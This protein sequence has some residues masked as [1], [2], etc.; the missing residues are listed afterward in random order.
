[1][2]FKRFLKKCEEFSICSEIGDK[3]GDI[4]LE[5]AEDRMTLYQIVIKGSGRMSSVFSSDY[6]EGDSNHNPFINLKRFL[7][8]H[9]IF[10]SYEPFHMYGFNTL[11]VN[12][13]WNGKLINQSFQGDGDTW[14]ICFDGEPIINGIKM[15]RMDYA[16]LEN[17]W[18][19]VQI[20]D[21]KVGIFKKHISGL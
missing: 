5:R 10:E 14:L 2:S 7:G 9:T 18:D 6:L 20:N 13:D 17:K 21:S 4:C 3:A 11:S 19:D 1:M 8:Q 16:K 15:R 12:E